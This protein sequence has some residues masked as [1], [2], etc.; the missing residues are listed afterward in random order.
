MLNALFFQQDFDQLLPQMS[1]FKVYFE[2]S[3][4]GLDGDRKGRCGERQ[5]AFLPSGL[6]C[7]SYCV[8]QGFY[9]GYLIYLNAG[10]FVSSSVCG[11]SLCLH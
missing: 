7:V 6:R 1:K 8:C 11:K 3:P 2:A 5:Q 4:T 10:A 9:L